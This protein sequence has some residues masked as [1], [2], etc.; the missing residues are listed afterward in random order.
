[1]LKQKA[2][3]P[4]RFTSGVGKYGP[5]DL[6][7]F[8]F[9]QCNKLIRN[10]NANAGYETS[11]VSSYFNLLNLQHSTKGVALAQSV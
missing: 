2:T 10:F 11:R 5:L 4:A 6:L 3:D 8:T 9:P 1:M 7:G